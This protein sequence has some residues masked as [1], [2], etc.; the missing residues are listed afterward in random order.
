M[1]QTKTKTKIIGGIIPVWFVW[2]AG[3]GIT[4][5][6]IWYFFLRKPDNSKVT[7]VEDEDGDGKPDNFDPGPY[8]E[9]LKADLIGPSTGHDNALHTEILA[10][11]DGR[12]KSIYDDWNRRIKGTGGG[13]IT[14][15]IDSLPKTI[16]DEYGWT[17]PDF[18]VVQ[19]IYQQRFQKLNLH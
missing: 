3:L 9:K 17:D 5:A 8:T 19:P 6:I 12:I 7:K 2:L 16:A 18:S 14:S 1:E 11:S 15:P 10:M 4:F 13:I